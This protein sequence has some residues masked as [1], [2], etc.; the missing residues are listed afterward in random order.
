M[1]RRRGNWITVR[2]VLVALAV[3]AIALVV[4][5]PPS[6]AHAA[7]VSSDPISG[8][9]L[10]SAPERIVLVFNEGVDA[11]LGGV[12]VFDER[13]DPVDVGS[14][15]RLDGDPKTVVTELPPLD[16]GAYVVAWRVV[17]NDGHPIRGAFTFR[18]GGIGDLDAVG[19]LAGEVSV[20]A[21]RST[22]IAFGVARGALFAGVALVIGAL[23]FPLLVDRTGVRSQ[24][25]MLVGAI[26][27][28]VALIATMSTV[29]LQGAYV[30]ARGLG[31]A[32][33]WSTT[34][35][36]LG[37]RYG[38]MALWRVAV[39]V[40][41]EVL[42]GLS[43]RCTTQWWRWAATVIALATA[44]TIA[45]AGHAVSGE[46]VPFA[47]GA[48]WVHVTA[49]GVW[50]GGLV[51]LLA[52]LRDPDALGLVQRFSRVALWA[53]IAVVVS[54]A[55]ATWRQVGSLD[56]LFHTDYGRTLLWKLAIVA[57]LL[58][59]AWGARR[60]IGAAS[61]PAGADGAVRVRV[62]RLIVVEI[63][64]AVL[65]LA[66]TS[67]LVET[68]PARD[69]VVRPMT[70][71]FDAG[72][73]TIDLTVDPAR[74]GTNVVHVYTFDTTGGIADPRRVSGEIELADPAIGPLDVALT[75]VGAG[76]WQSDAAD[77]PLAGEWTLTIS[78]DVDDFTREQGA[79][80]VRI[81]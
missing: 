13:S 25:V 49:M 79:V 52:S 32:W 74:R 6:G 28:V 51:V 71:T 14:T 64:L 7:L 9:D 67:I 75:R 27:V 2:R 56:A 58:L 16:P 50:L 3:A 20:A 80:S 76:H 26:G 46:H 37:T 78:V 43:R 81:R 18:I 47:V 70:T 5:A 42:F 23:A 34:M 31:D 39:L 65:V 21:P 15:G 10:E 77:F 44:A 63:V 30:S 12:L 29:V 53:V 24:T 62:R 38:E 48:D 69:E 45:L 55:F 36:V 19:D 57:A 68:P 1:T 35:N 33:S 60:V 11:E 73:F 40:V 4:V 41:A 54:G 8:A 61:P 72:T 17:S 22:S 66:A 59:V